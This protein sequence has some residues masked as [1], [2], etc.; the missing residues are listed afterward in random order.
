MCVCVS[1]LW[2]G[3]GEAVVF[4]EKSQELLRR[5]VDGQTPGFH[6]LALQC[7]G[8]VSNRVVPNVPLS[9]HRVCVCAPLL[10]P[11][12]SSPAACDGKAP[13]RN[14]VVVTT[15]GCKNPGRKV[16]PLR[17]GHHYG[18]GG[19]HTKWLWGGTKW[20][21]GGTQASRHTP[22]SPPNT[23]QKEELLVAHLEETDDGAFGG[24][25]GDT[26][27]FWGVT[28]CLRPL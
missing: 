22:P 18:P 27:D 6:P 12:S 7:G 3:V 21:P 26:K 17:Y 10:V 8:Q 11:P 4:A 15:H 25:G 9:P 20:A 24:P 23:H 19:R 2:D 1:H 16:A 13:A 28:G 5:S 14:H